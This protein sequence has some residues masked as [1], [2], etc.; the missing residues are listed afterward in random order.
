MALHTIEPI[1]H[2]HTNLTGKFGL[3][4]Q[5]GV[6]PELT[7]VITFEPDY[8]CADA[9][10]GLEGFSHI[11]LLWGFSENDTE[12]LHG[13]YGDQNHAARAHCR[14]PSCSG[15]SHWSGHRKHGKGAHESE[16]W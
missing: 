16:G 11:W 13:F 14:T 2:I 7:G 5:A 9:L 12:D 8:R 3:P 10:R 4:R 1:A 6:V 15:S